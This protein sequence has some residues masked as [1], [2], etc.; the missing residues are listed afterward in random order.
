M[1]LKMSLLEL[2]IVSAV[3]TGPFCHHSWG[4]SNYRGSLFVRDFPREI[5]MQRGNTA[6]IIW[7]LQLL[8]GS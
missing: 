2:S 8:Q 4:L 3:T 7:A 5:L 6:Y 1:S